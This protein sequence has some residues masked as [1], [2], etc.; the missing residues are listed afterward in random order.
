M[1]DEK[2]GRKKQAKSNTYTYTLVQWPPLLWA[3]SYIMT[4]RSFNHIKDES[5]IK[6]T[7]LKV[8]GESGSDSFPHTLYL[9]RCD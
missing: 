5:A 9:L 4:V 3:V 7:L 1:R 8:A 6:Q 2:E